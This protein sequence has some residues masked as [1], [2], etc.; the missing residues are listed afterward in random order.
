MAA[1][2]PGM[3]MRHLTASLGGVRVLL[4]AACSG[5][6]PA[7]KTIKIGIDLPLTG[8]DAS[9]GRSTLNGMLLAVDQA[10]AKDLPGGFRLRYLR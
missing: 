7:G 3:L 8:A 10:N 9:V 1:N 5:S 6:G 4:V 2:P